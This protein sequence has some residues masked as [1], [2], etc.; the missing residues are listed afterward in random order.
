MLI[1]PL[2]GMKRKAHGA[3]EPRHI[4]KYVEVTNLDISYPGTARHVSDGDSPAQRI[5]QRFL[6]DYSIISKE[7][8]V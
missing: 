5:N 8:D 6:I 7:C 2:C 3:Q 4:Y 1:N